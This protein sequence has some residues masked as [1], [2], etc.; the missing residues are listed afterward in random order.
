MIRFRMDR[1]SVE[2]FAMLSDNIPEGGMTLATGLEFQ[3]SG[4]GQA[5]A[6]KAKFTF[7]D[8][9]EAPKLMLEL[10]CEF[11]IHSDDA[12]S[13]SKD[14]KTAIPPSVLKLFAMHTVGT[15][16]GVLFAKTEGSPWSAVILPPINVDQMIDEMEANAEK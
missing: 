5:V 13:F 9:A 11:A 12:A 1:I 14:G 15:A 8:S 6:C 16:R 2:Q 7:A 4:D 10:R 3:I